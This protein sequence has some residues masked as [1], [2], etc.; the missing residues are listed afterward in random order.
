MSDV[1]LVELSF[2]LLL[3]G[4]SNFDGEN[5]SAAERPTFYISA[6]RVCG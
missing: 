1:G 3:I 6:L 5:I 2:K 4:K